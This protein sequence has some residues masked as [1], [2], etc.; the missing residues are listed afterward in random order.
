MQLARTKGS[1]RREIDRTHTKNQ[2][3]KML[4]LGTIELQ[5]SMELGTTEVQVRMGVASTG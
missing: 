1:H 3:T 2:G 5:V 4:E